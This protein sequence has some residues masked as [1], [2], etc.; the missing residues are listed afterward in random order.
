MPGEKK[1]DGRELDSP[2]E[3]VLAKYRR[4][5]FGKPIKPEQDAPKLPRN[6]S[7]ITLDKVGNFINAYTAWREYTEN[8]YNEELPKLVVLKEEY[9]YL[10]QV[11]LISTLGKDVTT[12]K[13]SVNANEEVRAKYREKME[14]EM[15][16]DMLA[17]KIETYSNIIASLSRELTRRTNGNP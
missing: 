6:I 4:L 1:R 11:I 15:F 7:D 17:Q 14:Q 9:D 8:L 10:Y 2:D 5:G 3:K 16:T 13:A 12:K